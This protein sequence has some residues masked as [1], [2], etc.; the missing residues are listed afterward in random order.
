[1]LCAFADEKE[2]VGEDDIMAAIEELNWKEHES[3]TGL[4]DKL[5]QVTMPARNDSHVTQIEVRS[6]TESVSVQVERP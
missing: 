3:N 5:R 4:Y 2:T 1:M 6:E